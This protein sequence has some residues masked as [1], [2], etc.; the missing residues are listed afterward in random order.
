MMPKPSL[1][2]VIC[3]YVTVFASPPRAV[4]DPPGGMSSGLWPSSPTGVAVR[5]LK[6]CTSYMMRLVEF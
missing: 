2:V 5:A 6:G 1:F 3:C 4:S